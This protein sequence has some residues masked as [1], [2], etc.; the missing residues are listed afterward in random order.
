MWIK[1]IAR[2]PCV[3][4]KEIKYGVILALCFLFITQVA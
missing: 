4:H 1:N 3:M 2:V